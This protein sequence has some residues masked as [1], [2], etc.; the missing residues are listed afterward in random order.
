MFSCI[1]FDTFTREGVECA[2]AVLAG[3]PRLRRLQA[4]GE[5]TDRRAAGFS[6]A[7]SVF[8]CVFSFSCLLNLVELDLPLVF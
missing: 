8:K 3:Q 1:N 2:Q 7:A 5:E 4:Q 6:G